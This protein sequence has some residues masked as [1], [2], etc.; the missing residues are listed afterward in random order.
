MFAFTAEAEVYN[1]DG[2]LDFKITNPDNKYEIVSGE[3]KIWRG[4]LSFDECYK[5]IS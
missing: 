5:Q 1:Y 3:Y 4:K 2:K